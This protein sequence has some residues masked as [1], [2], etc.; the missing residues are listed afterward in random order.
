M[1]DIFGSDV[2]DIFDMK[3]NPEDVEIFIEAGEFA[4]NFLCDL[5]AAEAYYKQ[6]VLSAGR[7]DFDK[8][9]L[10]DSYLHLGNLYNLLGW[11]S[12]ARLVQFLL[13]IRHA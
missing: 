13:H 1:H 11:Y 6:A 8:T 10:A 9:N 12:A 7:F 4:E 3:Y 2:I 5:E